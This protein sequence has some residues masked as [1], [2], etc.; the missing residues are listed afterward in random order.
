[1]GAKRGSPADTPPTVEELFDLASCVALVTGAGRGIG[2]AIARRFGEAGAAVAVHY[3]SSADG[4][5]A[6]VD[7]LCRDGGRAV[8]LAAE[9]TDG[10]Q[11]EHLVAQ[12]VE[13]LGRLDI[14][15]NN[16]GI[17]PL[18][19]LT[20]MAETEWDAVIDANLKSVFLATQAAARIM[21]AQ[22]EGGAIVNVASV[23]GL[24]PAPAHS[25]YTSA[26]AGVLMHTRSAALELG[27]E[28]IRVNAVSPGL[29]WRQGLEEEWPEGVQR[30][31]DTA[32]LGRLGRPEE[33]A[34]A[35]LFLASPAARWITGTTLLV[36]GGVL[37][38]PV[39]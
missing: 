11:V 14:L 25:H 30:W 23:E 16:A 9:L 18:S 39:F 4:A 3:R 5:Q 15:I 31:R 2:A 1:M 34:D 27:S 24:S 7:G 21:I 37:A 28:N 6:L 26:K 22:G 12:V 19:L 33:V 13:H 29:I 35:C 36:D 10:R 8:A 20:E 32:P 17:Y 38:R